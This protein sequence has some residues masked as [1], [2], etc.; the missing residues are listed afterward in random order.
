MSKYFKLSKYLTPI[1]ETP[2]GTSSWF[3]YYNYDPLNHDHTKL[4]ANRAE[5]DAEPVKPDYKVEVGYYDIK[6]GEWFHIG[7]S[8]SYNWPQGC[9]L[10]W[11][12]GTGNE[13]KVIYNTS[14]DNHH[15]AKLFDIKTGAEQEI[16]WAIY[17]ITPDGKKSLT[18]DMDRAHWTRGYHYESVIRPELD[19][20]VL[21]GDGIFEIDLEKNTRKLLIS[22][23]DIINTDY[24]PTFE[25]AKH[26]VEHIMIS[27]NNKRFCFL[28][29]FSSIDNYLRYRTRLVIADIDG[30]NLSVVDGWRNTNFSHFGWDGDDAF[31]IY[32]YTSKKE[33]R[34]ESPV[35]KEGA[36]TA[37][38]SSEVSLFNLRA[39][40]LK[41]IP[42]RLVKEL[43]IFK[44]GQ[45][46]YFQYYHIENNIPLHIDNFIKRD[47]DIDGHQCFTSDNRYMIADSYPDLNHYQRII[48][49]DKQSRKSKI[50]GRIYDVLH[51]K[52]GSCDLH[53][54]L[55]RNNEYLTIDTAYDGRHHM[56]LFKLN[57]E[58]ID[59][60]FEK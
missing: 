30:G 4:L 42:K 20:P 44:N 25:N 40:I 7:E 47:F 17:G 57:W 29:R 11:I 14:K 32:A 34:L 22:I 37:V 48:I 36:S 59:K 23:E 39:F 33:I 27:P 18:I 38:N 3:G 19:V 35:K 43:R 1:Y 28:H 5:H 49:Y 55:S 53:P 21:A 10:Q 13:N 60:Y 45:T 12:P 16:S 31:S 52:P 51:T 50:M 58:L 56:V 41:L 8:D 6:T 2:D 24:D 26:W 15:I 54:K 9:M 46:T